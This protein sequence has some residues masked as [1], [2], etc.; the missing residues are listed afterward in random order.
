MPRDRPLSGGPA[1]GLEELLVSTLPPPLQLLPVPSGVTPPEHLQH[2]RQQPKP[3]QMATDSEPGAVH[4]PPTPQDR[5]IV[6]AADAPVT[7]RGGR[8]IG[9]NGTADDQA[10]AA[11][12]VATPFAAPALSGSFNNSAGTLAA[13]VPAVTAV[14]EDAGGA[15]GPLEAL[16]R[17]PVPPTL[18]CILE[19]DDLDALQVGLGRGMGDVGS[20]VEEQGPSPP[21][22]P[23]GGRGGGI[24][25]PLG[26]L[27]KLRWRG[28]SCG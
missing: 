18:H 16:Y 6:H 1:A 5:G 13:A 27:M 2:L 7:G 23:L 12:G 28:G 20:I 8:S 11:V 17:V 14:N 24:R 25:M 26:S 4:Q 9:G 22:E 19:Q 21:L 10:A 15:A 3:A